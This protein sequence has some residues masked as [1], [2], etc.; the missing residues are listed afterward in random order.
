MPLHEVA[1]DLL[2]ETGPLAVSSANRTGFPAPTTVE[3]AQ[4]QLGD[5]VAVY[6]DGGPTQVASTIVD[7]TGT[8]PRLLREGVITRAQLEDAVGRVGIG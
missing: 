4:E 5:N 8:Q 7:V 3:A 2:Q 6:L 1:I